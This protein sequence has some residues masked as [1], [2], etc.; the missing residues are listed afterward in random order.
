M[1]NY[2]AFKES[3]KS[4]DLTVFFNVAPTNIKFKRE[5]DQKE[6]VGV[7][8]DDSKTLLTARLAEL[9]ERNWIV[10]DSNV[11]SMEF[12]TS[13]E[14]EPTPYIPAV[15]EVKDD[16][17]GFKVRNAVIA[18]VIKQGDESTLGLGAYIG[19]FFRNNYGKVID[20]IKYGSDEIIKQAEED[21]L[22]EEGAWW[23]FTSEDAPNSPL[24]V[25]KAG[26]EPHTID[27]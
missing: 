24:T 19:K 4:T 12:K 27:Q 1:S 15:T 14:T 6:Y 18:A 16:W 5:F 23:N 20:Y 25:F 9:K 17:A 10:F 3:S 22:T 11:K 2:Y 8:F 21:S 26:L 13:E 7:E